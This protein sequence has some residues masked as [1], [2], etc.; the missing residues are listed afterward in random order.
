MGETIH[1][2]GG[3]PGVLALIAL[4]GEVQTEFSSP[5]AVVVSKSP[6]T[7]NLVLPRGRLGSVHGRV[8]TASDFAAVPHQPVELL[9]L[10]VDHQGLPRLEFHR[11]ERDPYN[12]G[13]ARLFR[14]DLN[15][16]SRGVQRKQDA[17]KVR[18]LDAQ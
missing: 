1:I 15:T 18:G 13:V 11:R 2:E 8:R 14:Q 17:E 9:G 6:H 3:P 10:E 7:T 12:S 4:D 16:R 5:A